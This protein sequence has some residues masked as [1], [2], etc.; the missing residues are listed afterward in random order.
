VITN[1]TTL[2]STI[3]NWLHRSDL[4][5]VIPDFIALAE[6]RI[7]RLLTAR[8]TETDANLTATINSALIDLPT[9]FGSPV[10][11]WLETISPRQLLIF[12]TPVEIDY[13]AVQAQPN[14]WAIKG[15][16]IQLDRLAASAYP[17]TLRYVQ[18]LNIASTDTNYVLTNYPDIYLYGAL[19]E[20]AGYIR[21]DSRL[22]IWQSKFE[23]ALTEA[24][25]NEITSKKSTLITETSANSRFNILEG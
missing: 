17:L 24:Q 21:D 20:S 7:N 1:Y 4:T 11:L 13:V 23:Q 14:Y 5:A 22:V 2:Q 8:G 10:A 15:S 12:K 18:N 6:S 9:D 25:S 16:Q 3:A 19:L